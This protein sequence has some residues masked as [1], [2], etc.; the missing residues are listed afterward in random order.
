MTTE[1]ITKP[2][3]PTAG[4]T[5]MT[6]LQNRQASPVARVNAVAE[7]LHAS[8]DKILAA[9][10]SHVS[11]DRMIRLFLSEIRKTPKLLDCTPE[12]LFAAIGEA[13]QLGLETDGVLG[14]AYLIPYKNQAKLIA[15]FKGLLDLARRRDQIII[16]TRCVYAQDDFSYAEGDDDH[17]RHRPYQGGDYD[18][19]DKAITH[20]YLIARD[21]EGSVLCRNVWTKAQVEAHKEKYSQGWQR[22]ES[23]KRFDSPWHTN[24]PAMARK[25]LARD[26][27]ARGELPVSAEI[28]RLASQEE[29]IEAE[30]VRRS[31]SE[32]RRLEH[33]GGDKVPSS[34]DELA[35][36]LG[37]SAGEESQDATAPVTAPDAEPDKCEP[38]AG[39]PP[40]D[41]FQRVLAAIAAAGDVEYLHEI[42]SNVIA[43]EAAGVLS[44]QQFGQVQSHAE[45]A[46]ERLLNKTGGE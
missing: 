37:A 28:Q 32:N 24:W 46:M 9:L 45:A 34:A 31:I 22:A 35:D 27:I 39:E 3:Q 25:T 19:S 41:Y 38:Q 15:G 21:K 14:H 43:A 1:T 20:V 42:A 23:Y 40:E 2:D 17:I 11:A 4:P 36:M 44:D 13:A 16:K 30:V 5:A 6:V 33:Q 8:R 26:S 18:T 29:I 10:P 12:S 7:I